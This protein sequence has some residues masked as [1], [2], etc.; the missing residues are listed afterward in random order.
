MSPISIIDLKESM[1][2]ELLQIV[3]GIYVVEILVLLAIFV[4]RIESGV[5]EIKESDTIW[6]FVLTGLLS[7]IV[8]LILIM[9]VFAPLAGI[10]TIAG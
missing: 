2:A 7:Y 10:S 9:R 4:T 1:P 8:I 3:V 5:D 6:K